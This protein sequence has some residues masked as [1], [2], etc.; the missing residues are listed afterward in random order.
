MD[1]TTFDLQ[2]FAEWGVQ[3][4]LAHGEKKVGIPLGEIVAPVASS[5]LSTLTLQPIEVDPIMMMMGRLV[6]AGIDRQKKIREAK[7]DPR[8]ESS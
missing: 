1:K 2:K 6:I 3:Q 4:A 5:L 8:E 7:N